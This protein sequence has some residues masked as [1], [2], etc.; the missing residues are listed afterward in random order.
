MHFLAGILAAL[1]LS[2]NNHGVGLQ[3]QH[4]IGAGA[5]HWELRGPY[6]QPLAH[7][8]TLMQRMPMWQPIV[9]GRPLPQPAPTWNTI[10]H[11]R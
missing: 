1:S 8:P 5:H 10:A 11:R 2:A 3:M 4:G 7:G 9:H 6:W